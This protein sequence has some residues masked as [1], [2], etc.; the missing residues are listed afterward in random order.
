MGK[1]PLQSSSSIVMLKTFDP[2]RRGEN[3]LVPKGLVNSRGGLDNFDEILDRYVF[4]NRVCVNRYSAR[5]GE[6][7]FQ[8][9]SWSDI[10]IRREEPD[11]IRVLDGIEM[12]IFNLARGI[13]AFVAHVNEPVIFRLNEWVAWR[14]N[15]KA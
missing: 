6:S 11:E 5:A 12:L 1:P 7:Y 2:G 3:S 14:Q 13:S 4:E 8:R 10:T 15:R 9:A